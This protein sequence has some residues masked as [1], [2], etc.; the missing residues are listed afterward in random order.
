MK[1]GKKGILRAIFVSGTLLISGISHAAII[2]FDTLVT[3]S[4]SFAYDGDG[5]SIDDV[6]FTTTDGSGFN[7]FG[8]GEYMTFIDEPGIEGTANLSPDLRVDFLNGA[9]TTLNFG[10]AVN[11]ILGGVD[12]V[13]F[14]VFDGRDNLLIS[15]FQNSNFT[16]PDG[17]NP[18]YFPE[19][20]MSL[21]FSGVASYAIFDFSNSEASR[22]I[23]DNFSG[24]FGSSENIVPSTGTGTGTVT[25]PES[26]SLAL[27]SLGL[28]VV[29]F[30]RI[31]NKYK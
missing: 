22:Y 10:F 6:L 29:G 16:R 3:G 4:T 30:A 31:R 24:T 7:T 11:T 14:S 9:V 18:S 1:I 19:G 21:N 2:T 15:S 17:T 5:D 25:V 13:T 27:L 12:G 8:P 28:V 20:L 23:L 26:G